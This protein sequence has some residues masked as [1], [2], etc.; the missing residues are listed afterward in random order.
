MGRRKVKFILPKLNDCGGKMSAEW[1]VEYSYRN[2]HNGKLE[3]FRIYEGL[4]K[5]KTDEERRAHAADIIRS[6]SERIYAGWTPFELD[7]VTINNHI[8]YNIH[9][10]VYG[11]IEQTG[12]NLFFYINAF[13]EDKKPHLSRKTAQDYASKL[14]LFH[15][16]LLSKEKGDIYAQ[17][18]TNDLVAQYIHHMIAL[19]REK[20][21]IKDSRQR[22]SQVLNWLVKKQVLI[23]NPIYDL[24]D[25]KQRSDHSAQPM[26]KKEASF[27]LNHIKK[28]DK[29]LYLFCSMMFYCAIRPGTELRLLKVK[30]VNLFTNTITIRVE[31]GKSGEGVV[32]IPPKLVQILEKMRITTHDREYF[33]FGKEGKPGANTWGK[34][35]FR[36]LFNKYRDE[37]GYP[38]EYKLYSWKCTGAILFAMSGAPITAIRDHLRHKSTAYTDIYVSKKIGKQNDYVKHKFPEI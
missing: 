37:I 25:V 26:T 18:V 4:K 10:R 35:H 34:N 8:A 28:N 21:T 27:L 38:K 32:N 11:N 6:I 33:I 1:Y 30:D 17:E 3:R 14:R 2:E 19:G 31:N 22:I 29:Q 36:V 24:P 20:H 9:A 23:K 7:N 12:K 5:L 16:W 15:Q 13:L